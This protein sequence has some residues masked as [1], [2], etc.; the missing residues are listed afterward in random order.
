[1]NEIDGLSAQ[2]KLLF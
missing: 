1:L 2:E